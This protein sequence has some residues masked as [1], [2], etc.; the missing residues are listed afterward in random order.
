MPVVERTGVWG[1]KQPTHTHAATARFSASL[2]HI[3]KAINMHAHTHTH[4]QK[5]L[6]LSY[7]ESLLGGAN[8]KL[9]SLVKRLPHSLTHQGIM[10]NLH[11]NH[12]TCSSQNLLLSG[13]LPAETIKQMWDTAETRDTAYQGK[14]AS[15]LTHIQANEY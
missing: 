1:E 11:G 12:V 5:A 7:L 4:T 2:S 13:E 3:L 6:L 15:D 14:K 9:R 8:Q 10:G